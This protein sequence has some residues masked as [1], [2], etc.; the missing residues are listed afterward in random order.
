MTGSAAD[1]AGSSTLSPKL[2]TYEQ[3]MKHHETHYRDF[4]FNL[5]QMRT[6]MSIRCSRASCSSDHLSES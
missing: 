6:S 1:I 3:V 4:V 2:Q 5:S